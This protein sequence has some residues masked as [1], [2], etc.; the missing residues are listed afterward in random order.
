[1]LLGRVKFWTG[2]D[3][4]ALRRAEQRLVAWLEHLAHAGIAADGYVSF[5]EPLQVIEDAL[6]LSGADK[7][8]LTPGAS[9]HWQVKGLAEQARS[10]FT[11]PV[12]ELPIGRDY[13]PLASAA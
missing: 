4:Q 6:A 1:V 11:V 3:G 9:D 10:R 7:M 13:D 5:A 8:I 12:A 2:D